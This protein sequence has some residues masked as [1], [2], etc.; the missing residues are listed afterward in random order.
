VQSSGPETLLSSVQLNDT[1]DDKMCPNAGNGD[2][3]TSQWLST[4]APSIAARLNQAA[5]GANVTSQDVYDLISLCP[6]ETVAKQVTS[7]FCGL[8]SEKEFE[9]FEYSGDLDKYY[10]TGYVFLS[11]IINRQ[12]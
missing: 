5:P 1:L 8:F 9:A 2:L 10:G 4:Y 11:L 7:P 12:K 3:A 6:F